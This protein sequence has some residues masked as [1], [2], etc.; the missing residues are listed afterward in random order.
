MKISGLL[1]LFLVFGSLVCSAVAQAPSG[2]PPFTTFSGG[3]VDTINLSAL[4]IHVDIPVM[5]KP[6]RGLAFTY[7]LSFDNS[8]WSALNIN[9]TQ[10]WEPAGSFGWRGISEVF[11][12]YIWYVQGLGP[13]LCPDGVTQTTTY[14]GFTYQ[15]PNGTAH[16][17]DPM[18]D[19]VGCFTQ[20]SVSQ[21]LDGSGFTIDVAL[22]GSGPGVTA[23]LYTPFGGTIV[24]PIQFI[25]PDQVSNPMPPAP[26]GNATITDSNGNQL[27][28]SVSGS[29]V[30]FT[31]TLATTVMTVDSTN[32]SAVKYSY[33]GPDGSAASITVNYSTYTVAT[34]FRVTGIA[35][36]PATLKSLPSS[37]TFPD[38]S[39]YQFTYEATPA[40]TGDITGRLAS[41]TL[42]TGGQVS[43]AYDYTQVGLPGGIN[44][45]GTT[46]GFTRSAGGNSWKY[47]M[48]RVGLTTVTDPT[49][50]QTVFT[51][52][53]SHE[54]K[55]QIY[56]GS[57]SGT[58][59]LTQLT[60]YN[61]NATNCDTA[62]VSGSITSTDVYNQ[63]P[64]PGSLQSL[65]E[66][67][68]NSLGNRTELDEFDF[69]SGGPGPLLRKTTTV[70]APLGNNIAGKPASVT[71]T[72][73]AQNTVSQALFS[74]DETTPTPTSEPQHIA[75]TGARGNVT[76]IKQ[77]TSANHYLIKQFT[78]YDT[79]ALSTYTDV[80]GA[81]VTYNYGTGSCNNS[82]PTS[83]S[84]PLNLSLSNM[85]DCTG[86]VILSL[87]DVNQ[88]ATNYLYNTVADP[89]IWRV[90][91]STD[92]LSNVRT[93]T[94]GISTNESVENFNGSSS[95]VD[96]LVTLDSLGRPSTGQIR[97]SPG[98]T[99][100]DSLESDYDA[101]G[102]PSRSTSWYVGTAGQTN[103][104]VGAMTT[105]YDP[106]NRVLQQTQ[107]SGAFTSYTYNATNDVLVK[108]GPAPA[109][110]NLKQKQFE[111]DGL[112]RLTSVCEITTL[113]GSGSCGQ[114]TAATGF[115]TRYTYD[116]LNNIL[117][118]TQNAQ[119]SSPQLRSFTYDF[120]SRKTSVTAA[121][122]GTINYVY[123]S[124]PS[125]ACPTANSG[126]L[127]RRVDAAGVSTC[128]TY[129]ARR[130]MTSAVS[131]GIGVVSISGVEQSKVITSAGT[132]T[133]TISGSEQSQSGVGAHPGTPGTGSVSINGFAQCTNGFCDMGTVSITV[134]GFTDTTFY[135][136]G[137]PCCNTFIVSQLIAQSQADNNPYVTFSAGNGAVLL[138]AKTNGANTNYSLSAAT[139][140][141]STDSCT[142]AS[143]T[144]LSPCF[145]QPSFTPTPSGPTLTGGTDAFA[146]NTV[147][148]SGTVSV[149]VGTFTAST[150]Y[151]Q[152]D[153]SSSI[154][155]R[156]VNDPT[157]GLN[158]SSSPVTA[159]VNGNV[160]SVTEKSL[161]TYS[162]SAGS[163]S[164]AGFSPPSFSASPSVSS[165]TP[166]LQTTYDTGTVSITV[167]TSTVSVTYGQ[168]D[169]PSS[170]ASNL[171][172][173]INNSSTFPATASLFYPLRIELV[174]KQAGSF[175]LSA[176]SS[177][178]N[179]N[180]SG[181]SFTAQSGSTS[182]IDESRQT[183]FIYDAATVNGHAMVNVKGR[184]AE[185]ITCVSNCTGTNVI[186]DLGFSYDA[187]GNLTDTYESTP[188]SG[189]YYHVTATYWANDRL[190][191]LGGLPGL[192]TFT[193]TPDSQGRISSISASTG[194]NPVTS[195]TFNTASQVTGVTFGSG[196]NDTY[197]IDSNTGRITQFKAT[198]GTKNTT[199]TGSLTWNNNDSLASLSVNDQFNTAANQTCSYAYDDLSRLASANCG[200][201]WSQTFSYDPFGNITKSGS[202][203]FQPI[204]STATNRIQSLP[205]FTPTYNANG[206]LLTD[207]FH[208]Y[209][210]DAE[211]N[212]SSIDSVG[213][214]Y[215]AMGR[216]IEQSRGT[217]FTQIVYSPT[218]DKLALM[219][220]QTL[221]KAFLALPGGATAVYNSSG[222]AYYRHPDWLGSS[223]LATTPARK[224][225][226][227]VS[228]APFGES[229][230]Q[231][232]TV[233]LSFTGK[234]QDTVSGLY[235][236]LYREYSPAQG[237]WIA[238]DPIG[239][240]AADPA[241]PQTWNEYAY[242]LNNTT[243]LIDP[244]GLDGLPPC[245]HTLML[246][247]TDTSTLDKKKKNDDMAW[248][249]QWAANNGWNVAY[250]YSGMNKFTSIW[251]VFRQGQGATT[252][253]TKTAMEAIQNGGA[254]FIN[255]SGAAQAYASAMGAFNGK[256]NTAGMSD[257]VRSVVY[258]SPGMGTIPFLGGLPLV[259]G[260]NTTERY[261]DHGLADALVNAT[262]SSTA[263]TVIDRGALPK[264]T[265]HS[266][267]C[268][269]EQY[270]KKC[271]DACKNEPCISKIFSRNKPI[272][273]NPKPPSPPN[274]F[275]VIFETCG[276]SREGDVSCT[277]TIILPFPG[278]I[279]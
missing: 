203:T 52:S 128:Y 113:P 254:S 107:A 177:T 247:I 200:T 108:E 15:D 217:S 22:I 269:V 209:T 36:Y 126:D 23:K 125:G 265:K 150:S 222:L 73:G 74:Y 129:D 16:R 226:G 61:G 168:N 93:T 188:H 19:S 67:H 155:S 256:A 156:L 97:Q 72:D 59:L 62:T 195:T 117:T 106:L 232:G 213:L 227:D 20:H 3:A 215:D 41:I 248:I 120:V 204:Y 2:S 257:N 25:P 279:R 152:G 11:S 194:Q 29:I 111:Y 208:T 212:L 54:L 197:T 48:G 266:A 210:W 79:G 116:T 80:N 94:Y 6:G 153:T 132:A 169:T 250:P 64:G 174:A 260:S 56:Q 172:S 1:Q 141:D 50:N 245:N 159:T 57:T 176:T 7:I 70:Y 17:F 49:G 143:G 271:G 253:A 119:S 33:T 66:A 199:L 45:T 43:Y 5:G 241:D 273:N 270:A 211:G 26:V 28:S 171:V 69:G 189:G 278:M 82:Y 4:N 267:Q 89:H 140:Y 233:D 135:S 154:A 103:S 236:F 196:D 170:V 261:R 53:G 44:G 180:F 114:N 166:G 124:D 202:G 277:F 131:S 14:Q 55:R 133:I 237:R 98:G 35:E 137:S 109:G 122:S 123:D 30:T 91:Q 198:V 216:M 18:L 161:A 58:L 272:R 275:P 268:E 223:R 207:S 167:A 235:D 225:Y 65:A 136:N 9:G 220:G 68:Y 244:D 121:E 239:S 12:G 224:L 95:T 264:C 219:N 85:W 118:V 13:R 165:I 238:C 255:V 139:S 218:G 40:M 102:R 101:L 100:F 249:E 32:P 158:V 190:H 127:V 252:A 87:T 34:N 231:S 229:Y 234:N 191:T 160:I 146:G 10:T 130:R 276:I 274:P 193:F 262:A 42:P 186:T 240:G 51:F 138:T 251:D 164:S 96:M 175:S 163:S 184:L 46:V 242:A 27:T 78:Y 149:T 76:T 31:D 92:P 8:F 105:T 99:N 134:N 185:A 183:K 71:I 147:Y 39:S 38:S 178:T 263:G 112:G 206:S 60:C 75:V 258:L 104:T 179:S 24:P 173:A 181:P 84:L 86:G 192:P 115:L 162:L 83:I 151:G 182:G 228:Y 47:T 81:V 243:G 142:D 230:A 221:Q 21:A 110:E 246:G 63:L 88:Q 201:V 205:G 77:L 90:K 145:T 148:D 214:V 157:T 144:V 187:L 37:I 259:T